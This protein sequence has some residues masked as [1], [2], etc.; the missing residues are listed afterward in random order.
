MQVAFNRRFFVRNKRYLEMELELDGELDLHKETGDDL[1]LFCASHTANGYVDPLGK[2]L[3]MEEG[4]LCF[5]VLPDN[6]RINIRTLYEPQQS[7][8]DIKI[9]YI[10]EGTVEDP[11]FKYESSPPMDL[12]GI[13]SYTLFGQ[14][15]YKL[16]PAEQSVA[17]TSSSNVTADFAMEILMDRVES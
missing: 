11:Q 6:P 14:P 4:S 17:N 13:I 9:W 1:E 16:N 3:E 10:I 5:S 12:A 8:Q 15:F 2:H 7:D